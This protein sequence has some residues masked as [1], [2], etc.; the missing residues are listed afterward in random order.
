MLRSMIPARPDSAA[1]VHVLTEREL[2]G[3]WLFE[4]AI[5][6]G[7][8]APESR[9]E[10]RLAWVDYEHWSHGSAAPERVIRAVVEAMMSLCPE[11]G[12]PDKFDAAT[13]RRWHREMDGLVRERTGS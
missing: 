3:G 5:R 6:R 1:E 7:V 10:A 12:I 9:H 11:R 4:V 8:D 2:D 13:A